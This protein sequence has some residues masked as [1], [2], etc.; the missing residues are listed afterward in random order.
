MSN[1]LKVFIPSFNRAAQ[2]NLLLDSLKNNFSDY[3]NLDINVLY[4]FSTQEFNEGYY[5]LITSLIDES[6]PTRFIQEYDFCKQVKNFL[7]NNL[8]EH[9]LFFVD[10]IIFHE[11]YIYPVSSILPL[12][13]DVYCFSLRLGLNCH[14]Q[15][16]VTGECQPDLNNFGYK[17]VERD[18]IK[19]NWKSGPSKYSYFYPFSWD[20]H[21]YRARDIYERIH[22]RTFENPREFES[23][24]VSQQVKNTILRNN[25]ISHNISHCFSNAVNGVQ[26]T[27]ILSGVNHPMSAEYINDMYLKGYKL[28]LNSMDLTNIIGTHDERE[29]K[30]KKG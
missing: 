28:D 27:Q 1:K 19:W 7:Y 9:I 12:L 24:M 30:F 3:S 4:K 29:L 8:D 25:I 11:Q 20:G 14:E 2:L 15:Y 6:D 5:R 21:I 23:I 16:Y 22:D 17:L 26:R 13:P 10:D 18:H